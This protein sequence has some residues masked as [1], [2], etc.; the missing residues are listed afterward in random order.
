GRFGRKSWGVEGAL[1]YLS[2]SI[3]DNQSLFGNVNVQTDA[4]MLNGVVPP[5][6]PYFG[7]FE[8]P[9]PGGP[10]RPVI[11]QDPT[12]GQGSLTTMAN[13][14]IISGD[15]KL[16]ADVYGLRIGPYF[17]FPLSEKFSVDLSGGVALASVNSKFK[18]NE[19][20]TIP[21]VGS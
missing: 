5:D 12:P 7:T 2:V 6:P 8:G 4:Y 9:V 1:N 19:T 18:F 11:S 10:N 14:A 16:E 20:V 3:H 21:G 13:G 15:R 17:Q